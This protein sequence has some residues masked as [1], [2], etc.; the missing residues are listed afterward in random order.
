MLLA[1]GRGLRL[2]QGVGL[3]KPLPLAQNGVAFIGENAQNPRL[4]PVPP[5]QGM[6]LFIGD[7][8][9]FLGGV[10][11]VVAIGQYA[12][13]QSV[14]G[15]FTGLHLGCEPLDFLQQLFPRF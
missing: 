6:E 2:R 5:P 12:H 7:A 10:G 15:R 9:G 4:E 13:G 8:D 1:E 3:Q 14:H 11:S